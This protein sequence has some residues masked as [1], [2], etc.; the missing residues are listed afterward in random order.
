MNDSIHDYIP[1]KKAAE[2]IGIKYSLLMSRIYKG[3]IESGKFGWSRVIHKDEVERERRAQV[4]RMKA[5]N[6]RNQ[7]MEGST[8]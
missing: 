5:K 2:I 1:A 4:E 7:D 3:Q 8:G 6:A